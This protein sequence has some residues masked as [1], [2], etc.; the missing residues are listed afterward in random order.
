MESCALPA[1]TALRAGGDITAQ[2]YVNLVQGEDAAAVGEAADA[3]RW[4]WD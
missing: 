3:R 1:H 2:V 4:E